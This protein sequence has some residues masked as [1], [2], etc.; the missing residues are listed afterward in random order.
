MRIASV[1]DLHTDHPANRELVVSIAAEIHRRGADLVI[2]AGDVS[3]RDDR[4][5]RVI[6]AFLEVA[7]RVAYL[8]GN[9]DLWS[10]DAK[11]EEGPKP[12]TWLRYREHLRTLVEGVG[13]HYLPGAPLR[14][15][16]LGI[17]GSTGWYDYSF[18]PSWIQERDSSLRFED[19]RFGPVV[20]SDRRYISFLRADGTLM[21]DPEVARVMEDELASE[22]AAMDADPQIEEVLV[23]THVQPFDE[24]VYHTG[25]LPWE[26]F[27]AFMGSRR[28]GE[29]ILSSPKVRTAIHGHSHVLRSEVV[30][31]RRVYG[32][33]LGYPRERR[34]VTLE[35]VLRTRIGWVELATGGS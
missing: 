2:V 19:R 17:V 4:I 14:M 20:W 18:A 25:R 5:E 3:H 26:Y 22:L 29:I 24:V 11:V 9:H 12:D 7:D 23:V 34:G 21:T 13:G 6:R 32:T 31:G 27:T 10:V 1:S 33:A 16:S 35:E 8:P 28:L 15:G 30:A